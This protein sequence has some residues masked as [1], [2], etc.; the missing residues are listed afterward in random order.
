MT[1]L[2]FIISFFTGIKFRSLPN[3]N[4]RIEMWQG[5]DN[6]GI[7]LDLLYILERITWYYLN[8]KS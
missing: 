8:L 3:R 5:M 4:F 6:N 1:V 7:A 2:T